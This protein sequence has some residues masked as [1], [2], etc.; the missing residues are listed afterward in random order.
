MVTETDE[1]SENAIEKDLSS[2]DLLALILA[3]LDEDA[4]EDVVNIP[5]AGKSEMA[6][7]MVVASGRSSRHVGAL[8]EKLSDRIKNAT[9]R[10]SRM[11]GRGLGDWV[12]IDCG[13]TIVHI[14]RPEVREYYDLEKLWSTLPGKPDAEV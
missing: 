6:D 8:A 14:F 9:G 12:L 11:E 5:L 2:D 13:D 4:A 10:I 3:S 7:Y 1:A